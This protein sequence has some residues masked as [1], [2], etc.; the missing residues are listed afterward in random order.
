MN[1]PGKKISEYIFPCFVTVLYLFLY[2]PILALLVFSFNKNPFTY[3][4]MG[5]TTK[6]Y[7]ALILSSEVWH[8][9]YNSLIVASA[10]VVLSITMGTLL[11]FFGTNMQKLL[12]LFYGNLA[13]PEIILAISMIS[14]FSFTQLPLGITTLIAGHSL[15]GLGYVLPIIYIRFSELNTELLEASLD[16]G[17]TKVQTFFKI[18]FPWLAPALFAASLLVFIISF[19]DFVISFFCSSASSQT[20][21]I[22]IF[23]MIRSGETP[24]VSALSA[25]LLIASSFLVL[26]FSLLQVKKMD[27]YR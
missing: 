27:I 25:T 7:H 6:W 9:L 14:F 12:L 1:I 21:P 23:A 20:L 18:V 8:A 3:Q 5:F 19:D 13:M 10:S 26:L 16:L 22:Y 17:A 15:L 11:V 4:W 2:M 24:I